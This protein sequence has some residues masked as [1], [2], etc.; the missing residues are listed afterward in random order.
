MNLSKQDF[1]QMKHLCEIMGI[2]ISDGELL[3]SYAQF[4]EDFNKF[5]INQLINDVCL[6]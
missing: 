6:N 5:Q 2:E 3:R 1:E 4:C